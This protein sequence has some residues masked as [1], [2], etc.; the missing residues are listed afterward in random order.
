M[1]HSV[2]HLLIVGLLIVFGCIREDVLLPPSIA[3]FSSNPAPA[4]SLLII[5]GANFDPSSTQLF[6]NDTLVSSVLSIALDEIRVVLPLRRKPADVSVTVR[7]QYGGSAERPLKIIPPSPVI[8]R[9]IPDRAAIGK[10]IKIAGAFM[11]QAT[12]VEF[13]SPDQTNPVKATFTVIATDTVEVTVPAGLSNDAAD[14]RIITPSGTS[15]PAAFTVLRPPQILSFTPEQ[16][17]AGNVIQI[18]GSNLRYVTDARIGSIPAELLSV[19]ATI[20]SLRVPAAAN[21]DTIYLR[22]NA[23]D[24]QTAK[25]LQIIPPPAISSLDKASGDAGTTVMIFG[26]NFQGAFEV[27]FGNSPAQLVS[28]TGSVI[29]T[30]VPAG[31]SS[32]KV[33]VTTLAGTAF[34]TQDFVVLGAP[35]ISSF[36]PTSGTIGTRFTVTGVNLSNIIS[37]RIGLVNLKINSKSDTQAELE[38]L[39]GSVTGRITVSSTGN[40]F[41]TSTNFTV[42][43]TPQISSFTPASGTP[44]T[45]VTIVGVNFPANPEVKFGNSGPALVTRATPTEIVCQVPANAS[46]GKVNVNGALS[47][48]DFVLN[49][50]PLVTSISPMKGAVN[51]EVTIKGQYL[52]GTTIRFTNNLTATRVGTGTDTEVVVRVPTGAI[53]GKISISNTAG[54]TESSSDFQV[55][56]PP[57]ITSFSP[58]GGPVGTVVTIT[59]TNLNHT[60]EVRFANNV[61][62]TIQSVSPTQL[63]VQVPTGSVTGKISVKTEAVATAILSAADFTVQGKPQINSI[64]PAS[65]TINERVTITGTNFQNVQSVTFDGVSTSTFISVTAT[66]IQVRVP[67]MVSATTNRSINVSVRTSAD[68]SNNQV[69]SL[70]GTPTITKLSPNNNPAGWAFL[71]EGT[72]MGSVRKIAVDNKV[73]VIGANGI[74]LRAGNYLTTKVPDDIVVSSTQNKTLTLYY[75]SDDTGFITANYQVLSAPPP[76]VFPPPFMILPPPVPI[77]FVQNDISAWWE[78]PNFKPYKLDEF[79]TVKHHCFNIR[80][81]FFNAA[82]LVNNSGTFCEFYEYFVIEDDFGNTYGSTI[83]NWFGGWNRG[84]IN[85]SSGTT[86]SMSGQSNATGTSGLIFT[87]N[88]GRQLQL[89]FDSGGC[90][91]INANGCENDD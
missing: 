53:T 3:S 16:A 58:A 17:V 28:N 82:D 86:R 49:V 77:N 23:G 60:P 15:E 64:A 32:G 78:N 38:V 37:A 24:A 51:Q 30:R 12:S 57:T 11:D 66:A 74:D 46:T 39:T 55:L 88:N 62:A 44:G 27:K 13:K 68:V 89:S 72:N 65:G 81:N 34:S 5:K 87:D 26:S 43:G 79:T 70:L 8:Q 59:G 91:I 67:A 90:A 52:T 73:P 45:V 84:K 75:T 85:V 25:R 10:A 54:V 1:K 9:V 42:T 29:N 7:T 40:S 20:V 14:I 41:E 18:N 83:R 69:F 48:T 35:I 56:L 6:F 61:L 31:A 36:T 76:G 63:V 50:K 71:I 4:Q 22:G 19:S 80:G 2:S 47:A 33:S 21:A